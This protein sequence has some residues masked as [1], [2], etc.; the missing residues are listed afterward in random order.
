MNSQ[1]YYP[2]KKVSYG[3]V[4]FFIK[5]KTFNINPFDKEAIAD[6]KRQILVEARKVSPSYRDFMKA[7]T[8][9]T[10]LSES[11]IAELI[12]LKDK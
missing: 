10:G 11:R 5:T 9:A 6:S 4:Y 1:P 8:K 7:A 3:N 2:H 12:K